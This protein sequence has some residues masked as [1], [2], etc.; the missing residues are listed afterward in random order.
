M[1]K[2]TFLVLFLGICSFAIPHNNN[3]SNLPNATPI[4]NY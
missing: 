3:I 2:Y 1:N 4:G